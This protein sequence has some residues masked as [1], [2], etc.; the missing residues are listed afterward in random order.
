VSRKNFPDASAAVIRA[1]HWIAACTLI[2]RICMTMSFAPLRPRRCAA[3]VGRNYNSPRLRAAGR[4]FAPL[5][6]LLTRLGTLV[7]RDAGGDRGNR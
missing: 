6:S 2:D 5:F 7:V 4:R 3:P 1:D